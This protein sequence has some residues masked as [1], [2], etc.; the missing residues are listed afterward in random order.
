VAPLPQ[1]STFG[2]VWESQL[3][4]VP[5]VPG[6]SATLD[7]EDAYDD[8]PEIP[9]YLLAER[10]QQGRGRGQG[11][12]QGGRGQG[13]RGQ[14]GY[15]SA[16]D[17][18]RYG[19]AG[20]PAASSFGRDRSGG[21]GRGQGQGRNQAAPRPQQ[22]R[23]PAPP[24]EERVTASA[25][26][27]SE[28]PADVQEL[29][30][31]ELARRQSSGSRTSHPAPERPR[32]PHGAGR[33]RPERARRPSRC[34]ARPRDGDGGRRGPRQADPTSDHQGRCRARPRAG[35]G[36]A[37]APAKAYRRRTTKALPSPPRDGDGPPR[38]RQADPTSDHQG[39]CRARPRAGDGGRRGHRQ[40]DPTS[41]HQG[42]GHDR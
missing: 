19:R 27:W 14:G 33:R 6:V 15:R 1:H 42:R 12:G 35:D 7:D 8:E 31:A 10:R 41:D 38:P 20:A 28:V 40:A 13:G 36:A 32:S 39:R 21:Q 25:E 3:G 9:E 26:P 30:R 29:L 17:R 18:E 2:S 24:R 4:V 37:E 11:R 22:P 5:S 16:I 23:P 34:R